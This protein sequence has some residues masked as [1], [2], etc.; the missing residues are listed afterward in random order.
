MHS[1]G[2]RSTSLSAR[3]VRRSGRLDPDVHGALVLEQLA[4]REPEREL[5]LGVLD[6]VGGVDEV[7]PGL[8]RESPLIVPGA[9]SCGRVAPLIARQTAIAFR[10]STAMATSG[11]GR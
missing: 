3:P 2:A 4:G 10:P 5:L 8:E 11:L 9:A 6:A 7:L 1:D